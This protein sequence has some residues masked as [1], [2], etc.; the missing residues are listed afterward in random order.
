M[1]FRSC[2]YEKEVAQTLKDGHWP[3]GCTKELRAHVAACANCGDLVLVTKA[4]QSARSESVHESPPGSPGLLWWRAQLRRRNA[5]TEQ[6]SRPVTIAQTFAL[7]VTVVVAIGFAASQYHHGLRWATWWS[8]LT[9]S[10]ILH[11]L[12]VGSG[13]L[14]GKLALVIPSLAALALLSGLVVYLVSEKS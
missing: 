7:V 6:I 9:P 13:L 3:N 11:F 1:M 10:R 12:S 2:S 8:D 4:F 14:D 5:A